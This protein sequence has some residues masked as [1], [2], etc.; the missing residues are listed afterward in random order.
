M[1][2]VTRLH[3]TLLCWPPRCFCLEIYDY[4]EF[5]LIQ[6]YKLCSGGAGAKAEAKELYNAMALLI[7]EQP[8]V[9]GDTLN[10]CCYHVKDFNSLPSVSRFL[11]SASQGDW[12]HESEG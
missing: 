2:I 1:L 7:V 5:C 8:V 11:I 3:P 9:G 10:Y 12:L 6:S 4:V